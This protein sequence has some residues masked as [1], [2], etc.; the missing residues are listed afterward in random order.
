M[1]FKSLWPSLLASSSFAF[2]TLKIV[3]KKYFFSTCFLASLT[4]HSTVRFVCSIQNIVMLAPLTWNRSSIMQCT[5]RTDSIL[6]FIFRSE[7]C[8]CCCCQCRRR[9]RRHL[10]LSLLLLWSIEATHFIRLVRSFRSLISSI[11]FRSVFRFTAVVAHF[12]CH[13]FDERL[14]M[15]VNHYR[16][17]AHVLVTMNAI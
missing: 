16:V 5:G 1:S 8:C 17:H 12:D 11:P 9:R 2:C 7:R 3:K 15:R 14:C 10:S 6:V 4:N 13:L